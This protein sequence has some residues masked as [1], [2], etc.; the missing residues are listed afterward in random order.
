MAEKKKKNALEFDDLWVGEVSHA[1]NITA[2]RVIDDSRNA[3]V[4]I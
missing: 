4:V 2:N 3:S 1:G